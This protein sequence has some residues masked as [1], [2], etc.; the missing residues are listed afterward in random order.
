[1]LAQRIANTMTDEYLKLMTEKNQ[2]QMSRSVAFLESQK[3]ITDK[4][5]KQAVEA[6]KDFQ[7]QPRGLPYWRPNLQKSLRTW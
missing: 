2:E 6:L 1:V 7:S 4:E 3:S 5:L